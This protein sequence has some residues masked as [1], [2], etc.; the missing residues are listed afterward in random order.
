M[1]TLLTI[2][3]AVAMR[4]YYTARIARW[5]RSMAFIKATKHRHRASTCSDIIKRDIAMPW[6]CYLLRVSGAGDGAIY[7][8]IC[9][10]AYLQ[11]D[12]SQKNTH[13]KYDENI[14]RHLKKKKIGTPKVFQR[15]YVFHLSQ[16]NFPLT[17]KKV[18]K[19]LGAHAQLPPKYPVFLEGV[20]ELLCGDM[21]CPSWKYDNGRIFKI[22]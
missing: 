15:L 5:G 18:V 22:T 2:S 14:G 11:M 3:M 19:T 16:P 13:K 9:A 10:H 4:R 6:I 1:S 7:A 20:F 17:K 8:S 12:Q 21:G